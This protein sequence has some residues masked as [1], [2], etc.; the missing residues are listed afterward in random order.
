MKKAISIV[1]SAVLILLCFASC[2]SKGMKG[3]HHAEMVIK[4]YGTVK[5]ELYGDQAPLTVENFVNLCN[6]GFYDGLTFHRYVKDFVL[7]GGDPEGTGLGG[8]E[9]S[10][11]GEF[12]ANGVKNTIKHK[13][14][15]ISMARNQF[16]YDSASSQFFICLKSTYASDLDGQYA[17]FGK[18]TEGLDVIDKICSTVPESNC[19]PADQQPVIETIK[20][21]D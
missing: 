10:I 12:S 9:S 4:D 17:A 11:K 7:Q 3:T 5:I 1:M 2:G 21:I 19:I 14:G 16:D 18:I 20:V 8:C 6:K 13:R 15:V